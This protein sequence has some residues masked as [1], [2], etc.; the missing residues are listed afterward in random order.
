VKKRA[1]VPSSALG[2]AGEKK[3]AANEATRRSERAGKGSDF[4]HDDPR[5]HACKAARLAR[6]GEAQIENLPKRKE[7]YA[8]AITLLSTS[9]DEA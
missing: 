7:P 2:A 9:E 5:Y 3:E 1:I 8:K 6:F 4:Y